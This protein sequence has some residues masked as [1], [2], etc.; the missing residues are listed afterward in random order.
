V[1][2]EFWDIES[3]VE[4]RIRF[5]NQVVGT[6]AAETL[7]GRHAAVMRSRARRSGFTQRLWRALECMWVS[8]AGTN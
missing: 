3:G 8:E 5:R 2:L 1:K 6:V 7:D 4:H